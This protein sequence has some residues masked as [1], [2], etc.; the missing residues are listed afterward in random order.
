M[1][2]ISKLLHLAGA[3]VAFTLVL[4]PAQSRIAAAHPTVDVAVANWKFTPAKVEAHVGEETTIRFTSSE[5]VH[6]VQS[7]ALGIP[8]TTITPGKVVEVTFTPKKAGTY[9]L[10]CAVIC[11]EGHDKMI[12]TVEVKP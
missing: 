1:V 10:P 4:V 9:Q 11:G 12:L 6:G 2:S 8:K 3:A 5:G 7:D